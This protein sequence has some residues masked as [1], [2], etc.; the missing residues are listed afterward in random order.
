MVYTNHN[1]TTGEAPVG[2]AA[3]SLE[4]LNI[5]AQSWFLKQLLWSSCWVR[6]G[7]W[8]Q[9]SL[10]NLEKTTNYLVVLPGPSYTKATAAC[11]S[12]KRLC[13]IF[14]KKLPAQECKGLTVLLRTS[15]CV[16]IFSF[17]F[18]KG[19]E[20]TSQSLEPRLWWEHTGMESRITLSP[21]PPSTWQWSSIVAIVLLF[22]HQKTA[23]WESRLGGAASHSQKIPW[24]GEE[25]GGKL[26]IEW[27]GKVVHGTRVKKNW[28]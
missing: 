22:T 28:L 16:T 26:V 10:P 21:P 19:L 3:D 14:T 23:N 12:W 18:L 7:L 4:T 2:W 6:E 9:N 25:W 1:S 15:D 17:L 11:T 8:W 27:G 20:E 13:L 5:Q 24:Q